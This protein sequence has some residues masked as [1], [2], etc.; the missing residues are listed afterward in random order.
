MTETAMRALRRRIRQTIKARGYTVEQFNAVMYGPFYCLQ[1]LNRVGR[2]TEA[3]KQIIAHGDALTELLK[4]ML[5]PELDAELEA[6]GVMV[7]DITI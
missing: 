7:K 2:G 3:G 1:E 5:G 4:V 6:L